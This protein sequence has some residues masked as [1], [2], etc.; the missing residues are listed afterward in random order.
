ML[1]EAQVLVD[2]TDERWYEAELHRLR[3]G[4]L[5]ESIRPRTAPRNASFS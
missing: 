4:L 3:G 5:H 1:H 2:E